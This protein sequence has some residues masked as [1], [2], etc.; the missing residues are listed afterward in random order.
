MSTRQSDISNFFISSA[1][2]KSE[3]V[4]VSQSS[5]D[6]K[7]VDGRSTSEKRKVESVKLVD[8]SKHNNHDDTGTQNVERENNIVSEA[9]KQKTLGSSSSSSDAVSSNNDSGASTPIPLPIKEPPLESNARND[10]LKGHATFAEMVKAFTKIENT[11]KRLEI[12]D[13]M[14]TYFFGILRDHPSDLLACVYLSIN[15][16]GPDYSGLELGIGESIIMKAIGESTGQTLQQI[17]LSFHKVGDLGLVAQTSRQNQPTMFKPAALTIPFLFDS[18]KKIAQ[19]SGNQSQNRKIG[20]IK[21]LLSSCEGAEPKY[22][23]R[24]LEGKLRLQLAEKTILVALANATAQYHADK[25]GE[26]LSQQDR[27]EGEQILRDVYCQLPSYDLIVPHLIEHGLGTLRET[28]K[29]TPG[30]PTK[31]MLAKPTK[32]ISEVLNTFDQAAFTCEYKYDGERA[33]VHFTEDGKFYVFSRNSENMSVRY[34]DI[35][36]SVSK[37]KKP[38][39]RSF[40]LDCEAVGWDR[41]ENKILPFQKLATRKRKDVKI[42]DIKVRACLFAFD[43]LY[44]NGQPLLET[45]LNERRKLLYS[46]FQ[47]STGDFTFAKHSDQ[48]SIESIEEFLEESVKDSCEGL[49]VKML[50]GPDSHYEPSKRSRH[51]LKVKKDYLSGVGDSL[52][53]IVIGAYYGKGK[54]TSVYGAF[55]LGCYDPDTETVQSICKLGTG[56]SEEHLETFYNQLKDIVIS[57]KK[58]FYAHSDVPAHQPDVWFEPKYLW[59]VLAADLS[60]SPVYKAAIGYVQEDKGISLRFPRFIRIREDKSWEDATTSE[61]VSEFYR[62]QVAYSQKEKEGSPAAEDY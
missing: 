49:M 12:I 7:N 48:K 3:H 21:R 47:P 24:A 17:K 58:D 5:S 26:K 55:L 41:D 14:G 39:A 56:F 46:M 15:K 54:R 19:M 45:P 29:L 25:N 11:S 30:I 27:I 20:V 23:I 44:L 38:D 32:Q 36:A 2:H 35:S 62:S 16:L 53:L 4:E 9:K 22:L 37:W 60:L 52:D 57:K 6:S 1:S 31:P 18:L 50:E 59:E 42:G 10:K 13:I 33:Q 40:I 28:C 34:P 43:I 61:Q 8:E 51:W